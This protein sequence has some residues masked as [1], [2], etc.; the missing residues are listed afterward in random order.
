MPLILF[1]LLQSPLAA[2]QAGQEDER[3]S[4]RSAILIEEVVVTA[5]KREE[6]GQEVPVAISAYS[7]EQIEAL[8]VRTFEDLSVAMPNVAMDDVAT[9]RGFANFSVRGLGLNSSIPAIDPTVG[10]FIDGVYLG[11]AAGTVI[12]MYDIASIEVLR[13]PQGNLFGRNV[14]GGAV[15]VYT[16]GPTDELEFSFR[17]AVEGNPNGDGGI[18]TY[19]SA[20]VSG[21]IGDSAGY[22]LSVY[23][24]EDDGWFVNQFDG[25][26]HGA[27]ST[28]IFRPVFVWNPTD[29]VEM[30]LRWEHTE[31]DTDGPSSQSHTNGLGIPGAFANFERDSFDFSID[32]PGFL[33]L[34]LD[35]VSFQLDW[36]VGFGNGTI[37]NVFGWRDYFA[38]TYADIDAQ[39]QW[40]F[41]ASSLLDYEQVSNEL[42]YNGEFGRANVTVGLYWFDSTSDY[43]EQRDLLGIALLPVPFDGPAAIQPG[44]GVLD[45]T[46]KAVFGSVDF[47]ATD[48]L[49]LTVGLRYSDEKKDAQIANLT[50]NTALF[51]DYLTTPA[52]S[53]YERTCDFGFVDSKTWDEV[54]GKLGFQYTL[55]DTARFYGHWSR[56]HRS[57]GYN[58]RNTAID[59]VNLGPGPFDVETVDSFELGYKSEIG[60]RGRLNAAAFHTR[61]DDMQ[62]ELN[63]ADPIAGVVQVIRNTGNL[64]INGI[65][66]DTTFAVAENTVLMASLGWIDPEYTKVIFDLN[67]DGVV[68]EADKA[69]KPPRAAE[70]TYS[71][72]FN[73]DWLLGNRGA[74]SLR[75]SYAYRDDSFYTDN[76]LGFLLDQEMLNAGIDYISPSDRWVISLYGQNLLNSVN[77][78]NDTQLPATLQGVPTGGTFAP[79]ARGRV[80]GLE[81]S[82]NSM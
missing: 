48:N 29:S 49:A 51:P 16:K 43:S 62:R 68:D 66:V 78:G 41:H 47:W 1:A 75:A 46:S 44:G 31:M 72:G 23:N 11:L 15:L 79:L 13:G 82:F 55:S 7:G 45:L 77:H 32:E 54:S 30:K 71:V 61:V 60:G 64:E 69:L 4:A 33:D 20:A 42:R 25:S 21:P 35:F 14:T 73:Q 8:K 53:V 59:V 81:V 2:A 52:C 70:W 76:N 63:L 50:L 57:G 22:R 74:V 40:L 67:G 56:G 34:E 6:R 37:T 28:T 10:V 39:P 5:R 17:G 3:S 26:D 58:L 80:V 18:A 38:T 24:N 9:S 27:A 65:E 36:D 19:A 12:D